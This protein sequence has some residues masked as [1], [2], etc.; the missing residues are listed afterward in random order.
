MLDIIK[1][2]GY[3]TLGHSL[4]KISVSIQFNNKL[5]SSVTSSIHVKNAIWAWIQIYGSSSEATNNI[6]GT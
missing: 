2:Q 4:F 1:T 5:S 3:T 6:Y